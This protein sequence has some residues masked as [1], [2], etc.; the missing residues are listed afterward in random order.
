MSCTV[1]R[2]TNTVDQSVNV[3]PPNGYVS[4]VRIVRNYDVEN[5]NVF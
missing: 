3:F 5:G 2:S 1:L 4:V